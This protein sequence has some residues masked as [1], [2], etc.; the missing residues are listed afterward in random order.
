[1]GAPDLAATTLALVN[2]ASESR[3]E[4]EAVE[5]VRAALPA[6][7]LYDDGEVLLYGEPDAPIV[8]AGHLDTIP[9]QG[10]IPGRVTDGAVHGVGASDM[11]GGVAVMIELARAR[12]P[13]RYLFFTREE[14]ALAESPLPAIFAS[15]HLDGTQLAVV[16]EPTDNELH[17]GCL[18]NLQARITFSGVS[19]HSARPWT[20]VNAIHELV[21]GLHA[22]STFEP[23]DVVV[24][25]LVYRE[26]V[27]A[28]RI[29]GGIAA[30]VVPASATVELNYRFMREH[31]EER[32]RTFVPGGDVEILHSA[33]SA[34]PA[35]DNPLVAR[36]R[37]LAPD[38]RPKQAWTPVAQFAEQGIDAINY[39]PGATA[40]AHKQDEQIPVANLERCFE[41]LRE[42]LS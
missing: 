8:L 18:G 30:N 28:V 3:H 10:N 41:T 17:A 9:A 4:A 36:L 23:V 32:L 31:A 6:P 2:V 20:G 1:M 12:V 29:E 22:L 21:R 13:G 19:A 34:P 25:G 39:G 7:P 38:V 5:F 26:V 40:Y 14:V 35:L 42:F 11:K 15:G 27:S 24:D 37:T 33:P 16:L